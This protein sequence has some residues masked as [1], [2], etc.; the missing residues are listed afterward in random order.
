[1]LAGELSLYESVL[2]VRKEERHL[3]VR[4]ARARAPVHTDAGSGSE[5]AGRPDCLSGG[6]TQGPR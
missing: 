2:L 1:M 3:C 6:Q 4:G 5:E